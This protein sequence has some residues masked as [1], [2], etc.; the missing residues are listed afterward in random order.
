MR[1]ETFL[2]FSPFMFCFFLVA[3]A[4]EH[5]G[6]GG[7]AAGVLIPLCVLIVYHVKQLLFPCKDVVFLWN[8]CG[9]K[10]N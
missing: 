8:C 1:K 6:N 2:L 9:I 4:F 5:I 10:D 7:H 3:A